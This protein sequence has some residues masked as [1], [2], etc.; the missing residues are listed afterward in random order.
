MPLLL[1]MLLLLLL[2]LLL[3]L[4][5]LLHTYGRL[6]A[7]LSSGW[8]TRPSTSQQYKQTWAAHQNWCN[9]HKRQWSPWAQCLPS[10]QSHH[11]VFR[12]CAGWKRCTPA[13]AVAAGLAY[14]RFA[15]LA[16]TH[17]IQAKHIAHNLDEWENMYEKSSAVQYQNRNLRCRSTS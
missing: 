16:H 15:L 5:S 14:Q 3:S 7:A 2:L 12:L 13:A 4:F 10:T 6:H 9:R 8:S 17:Y 11:T 1:L